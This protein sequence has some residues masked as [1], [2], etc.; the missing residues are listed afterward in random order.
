MVKNRL[1]D[2]YNHISDWT[3]VHRLY[4]ADLYYHSTCMRNYLPAIVMSNSNEVEDLAHSSH[5]ALDKVV[6][7]LTPALLSGT[8]FTLSEVRDKVNKIMYPN[9]IHN[10]QV[11]SFLIQKLGEGLSINKEKWIFDVFSAN[12]SA[13][14]VAQK[15]WS[16]DAIQ[17]AAY[18]LHKE[19]KSCT[20]GL[21]KKHCDAFDL[22]DA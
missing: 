3:D 7:S 4:G 5:Q 8:G 22:Q 18:I 13:D 16:I 9:Q 14:D 6:V 21:E 1:N 11:K 10:N 17:D 2:V 19:I 12:Q 20:F 15:V